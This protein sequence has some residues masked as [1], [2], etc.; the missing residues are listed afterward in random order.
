M[1]LLCFSQGMQISGSVYDS[2]GINKMSNVVVTAVRIKDSLLLGFTRTNPAG[3]FKL[4]DLPVDT[5]YITFYLI[6]HDLKTYYFFGSED[7]KEISIPKVLMPFKTQK[8]EEV[9]VYAY[10]EP[11]YYRGDTLVYVADSF[12][13]A[14]NAV[15]EDLFK[16]LPGITLERNGMITAQG[17]VVDRILVDGDEFFGADHTVATQNLLAEG[18]ET[19]EVYDKENEDNPNPNAEKLKVID[20]KLK[21]NFKSGYFGRISG[22]SDFSIL[23]T[24][25][26]LFSDPFYEGELLLN[27]FKSNR[28]ISVFSLASNTPVTSFGWGEMN[29]Y[30]LSNE[31]GADKNY[32]EVSTRS[33]EGVPRT[34]K[35]GI[36][37]ADKF[38]AKKRIKTNFSYSYN[39]QELETQNKTF[40]ENILPDSIYYMNDSSFRSKF[41]ERHAIHLEL[42]F[43]LWK[44]ATL[45][46]KPGLK[47]NSLELNGVD[48]SEFLTEDRMQSSL[49]TIMSSETAETLDWD[50][51]VSFTQKFKKRGRKLRI[52]GHLNGL[53]NRREQKLNARILSSLYTQ[54]SD[55][56]NQFS[57]RNTMEL[58]NKVLL[59]HTEPIS[60]YYNVS[61]QYELY[62]AQQSHRREVANFDGSAYSIYNGALSADFD[63][64]I[65]TQEGGIALNYLK[66]K[67]AFDVGVKYRNTQIRNAEILSDQ[68]SMVELNQIFPNFSFKMKTSITNKFELNYIT[69]TFL[70]ELY[71][72]QPIVDNSFPNALRIGNIHLKP[73]Y[74]N[75]ISLNYSKWDL[76]SGRY[77]YATAGFNYIQNALSDS[78][79]YD[80]L[81]RSLSKKVN[82]DGIMIGN[83]KFG[84]GIPILKKNGE[85]VTSFNGGWNRTKSYLFTSLNTTDYISG[86]ASLGTNINWDSLEFNLRFSA[87]YSYPMNTTN[88]MVVSPLLS[89]YHS[90]GMKWSLPKGWVLN[91]TL[92]LQSFKQSEVQFLSTI[93]V[94]NASIGKKF[95][96]TENLLIELKGNDIFNQNV[97]LSREVRENAIIYN[98]TS[99]IS[100]YFL[101][102][103]TFRFNHKGTKEKD[104]NDLYE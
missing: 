79:I 59:I 82:L 5:F 16:K 30:G 46:V 61:F 54:L 13:L 63:R 94:A 76:I 89:Q 102:K 83:A 97:N 34:L 85:I 78:V 51:Y 39:N 66:A 14:Q 77:M 28:K 3:D 26:M 11:I 4:L 10:K 25:G 23:R 52:D 6:N 7:N 12:Q 22:A 103:A 104:Y 91:T 47:M 1:P 98:R 19:V 88:S 58:N 50:S 81:G 96:K 18:V 21:K 99:I 9:I 67:Y 37:Y 101:L 90:A 68:G 24:D 2:T 69:S 49:S 93:F 32:W 74:V 56:I 73:S 84:M 8:L 75:T 45:T 80:G 100:R 53:E 35:S 43:P 70:P 55:S 40:T 95:L 48:F 65:Q 29:K 60:K 42:D 92:N 72:H 15:V 41:Y 86:G 71:D 31:D 87:D 36:Y 33:N 17:E 38:G 57:N 20:I 64:E 44:N 62:K 27:Y